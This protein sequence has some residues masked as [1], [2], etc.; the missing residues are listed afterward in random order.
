MFHGYF[1]LC[2]E[3]ESHFLQAVDKLTKTLTN[4]CSY[5]VSEHF[6][7][8]SNI[9]CNVCNV[10]GSRVRR[11][12]IHRLWRRMLL[13]VTFRRHPQLLIQHISI[14]PTKPTIF[15][16]RLP[17]WRWL[18]TELGPHLLVKYPYIQLWIIR[19]RWGRWFW[20]KRMAKINQK[21]IFI[22]N[23]VSLPS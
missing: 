16:I 19:S 3:F 21:L 6:Y 23:S 5:F 9:L 20:L 13:L 15:F 11:R 8:K 1:N 10:S 4:C 22:P 2:S 18:W 14:G 7:F 12:V 17:V